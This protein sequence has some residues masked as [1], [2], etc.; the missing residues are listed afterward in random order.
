[1]LCD[2]LDYNSN[3]ESMYGNKQLDAHSSVL[4]SFLD[5]R[6]VTARQLD[7][8]KV[9]ANLQWT[10]GSSVT[11]RRTNSQGCQLTA[12]KLTARQLRP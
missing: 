10:T 8:R 12:R 6:Q 7:P 2:E 3:I 1:M 9:T 11:Y 5:L 4:L